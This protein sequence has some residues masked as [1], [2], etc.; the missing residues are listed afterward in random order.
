MNSYR[1]VSGVVDEA[2]DAMDRLGGLIDEKLLIVPPDQLE[3]QTLVSVHDS[4]HRDAA[5][6]LE[7]IRPR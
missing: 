7:A 2:A 4:L 3:F 6:P 5:V 1:P